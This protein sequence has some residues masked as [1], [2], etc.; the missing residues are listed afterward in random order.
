M[1]FRKI[2]P[3]IFCSILSSCVS[4]VHHIKKESASPIQSIPTSKDKKL[5][6]DVNILT[7]ERDVFEK[8]AAN[9]KRN[10]L[11]DSVMYEIRGVKVLKSVH[12]KPTKVNEI[13]LP[14]MY[15]D[16]YLLEV[17]MQEKIIK[18]DHA[19]FLRVLTF[20]AVPETFTKDVSFFVKLK[21]L[22]TGK[23]RSFEKSYLLDIR[24]HSLVIFFP[25][26]FNVHPFS[27]D[28]QVA[29]YK[30]LIAADIFKLLNI[31]AKSEN[32]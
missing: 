21:D 9:I 30:D 15:Q 4:V 19:R 11:F 31:E 1:H 32:N 14:K 20:G 17:I 22:K 3:L 12:E 10:R 29:I 8:R 24:I 23:I 25:Y 5:R 26:D 18:E 7:D 6:L 2:L 16:D 13:L 27:L 28:Q